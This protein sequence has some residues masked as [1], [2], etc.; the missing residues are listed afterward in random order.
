[1]R[2]IRFDSISFYLSARVFLEIAIRPSYSNK[3]SENNQQPWCQ[4]HHMPPQID[5]V[6][7]DTHPIRSYLYRTELCNTA[8]SESIRSGRRGCRNVHDANCQFVPRS[9]RN[10]KPYYISALQILLPPSPPPSFPL[11]LHP[12][13]LLFPFAQRNDVYGT[14]HMVFQNDEKEEEEENKTL[15]WYVEYNNNHSYDGR[16]ESRVV[17]M[18]R[19]GRVA[20][21][22]RE[23]IY[24]GTSAS[25]GCS[26]PTEL[27]TKENFHS[28]E[29]FPIQKNISIF[30]SRV[31][32]SRLL[33]RCFCWCCLFTLLGVL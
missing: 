4:S 26:R 24:I 32:L 7:H 2:T 31:G 19:G 28:S 15:K 3:S 11:L 8:K 13:P 17:I 12:S 30:F 33:L 10:I 20:I 6:G 16:Q 23:K 14:I 1:M 18:T 9:H 5:M 27:T 22:S 29:H 25:R 21:H